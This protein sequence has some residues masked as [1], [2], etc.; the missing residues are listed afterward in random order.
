MSE[1]CDFLSPWRRRKACTYIRSVRVIKVIQLYS[2]YV[3][4]YNMQNFV[5]G[6]IIAACF[7]H[8]TFE[9]TVAY[10][11][12]ENFTRYSG[13]LSNSAALLHG[14]DYKLYDILTHE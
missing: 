6:K 5:Q 4:Y 12:L 13:N 2:S 7:Q 11:E 14:Q 3:S 1:N 9:T 8:C 10:N